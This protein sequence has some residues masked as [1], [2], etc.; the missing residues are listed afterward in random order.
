[1]EVFFLFVSAINLS[2]PGLRRCK[3]HAHDCWELVVC[4]RGEAT[5]WVGEEEIPFTEGTIV[6]QMPHVPHRLISDTGWQDLFVQ[7]RDYT[8]PSGAGSVPVFHDDAHRQFETILRFCLDAFRRGGSDGVALADSL[9]LSAARLLECLNGKKKQDAMVDEFVHRL[10][11]HMTDPTLNISDLIQETGYC[12]DAFRRRFR[13]AMGTTPTAYLIQRRLEHA[14]ALLLS[15][16]AGGM[17][18]RQVA[19]Q[20]GFDDPYYFSTLF[21]RKNGVSPSEY[22][23]TRLRAQAANRDFSCEVL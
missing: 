11:L 22:R 18:V 2:T 9:A 16:G 1:M 17:T 6:C 5:L 10:N 8:P 23:E 13:A 15:A 20:C 19:L 4:T 14:K 7:L 12:M 3:A 21:R